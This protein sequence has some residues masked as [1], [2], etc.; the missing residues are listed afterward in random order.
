MSNFCVLGIDTSNYRTSVAVTDSEG[1][2]LLD[3]RKLLFV[4]KGERGLR[5]SDALFQHIENLPT[6]MEKVRQIEGIQAVAVSTRPR[7][8]EGSY[9]PCFKAGITVAES[10]AAALNVPI[11]KFSHQEGHIQAIKEEFAMDERDSFLAWH[12]SGGTCELLE[13]CENKI[14]IIGGSKDISFGQLIDRIGVLVGMNFPAGEEMDK[15]ASKWRDLNF[16]AEERLSRIKTDNLHFNLSG[17]ETQV[18]RIIEK[19]KASEEV[20]TEALIEEIFD[21]MTE[22]IGK[23]TE[24]AV[25]RSGI[26][27]VVFSGG[28]S[29]SDFMRRYIKTVISD[30]IDIKFGSAELSGDNAVG[31]SWL[32]GKAYRNETH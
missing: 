10:V 18:R 29:S 19:N 27:N 17:I 14:E 11:Y 5:Q 15:V 25:K 8:V 7:P 13:V 9:M 24:N 3:E 26:K 12:L 30:E 31:I 32:G 21:K 22:T 4:K 1:N 23:A 2:I 20:R 28:V 6:L 16:P